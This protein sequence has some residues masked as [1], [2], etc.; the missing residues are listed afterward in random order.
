MLIV[1]SSKS[2]LA[3]RREV[4]T[5]AGNSRTHGAHHVAHTLINRNFFDPF[6]ASAATPASSIVSSVTGVSPHL[7]S[8]STTP[9]LCSIHFVEHPIGL[10]D[11]TGTGLP[12]R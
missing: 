9:A 1:T 10:V 6:F 2:R 8:A 3:N 12:A 4:E 11:S 5:S 7:R